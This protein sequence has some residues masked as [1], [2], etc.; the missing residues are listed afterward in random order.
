[1]ENTGRGR[2]RRLMEQRLPNVPSLQSDLLITR[3]AAASFLFFF[4]LARHANWQKR[5]ANKLT[6]ERPLHLGK[7]RRND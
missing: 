7:K 2:G 6:E 4:Y 5:L 3:V 1:M